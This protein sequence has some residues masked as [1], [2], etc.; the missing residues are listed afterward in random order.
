MDMVRTEKPKK[1]LLWDIDGTLVLTGKA[2]EYAMDAALAQFGV[3]GSIHDVD[4]PGRTDRQIC[5]MLL[6]YHGIP[7]TPE[8]VQD[9]VEAYL[10]GLAEELPKRQ[11]EVLPGVLEILRHCHQRPDCINALLTG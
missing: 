10:Q 2:G 8:A 1:L 6:E 7:V 9:F 11:G 3:Q 5:R 4:Y